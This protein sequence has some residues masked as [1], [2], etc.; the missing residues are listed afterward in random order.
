MVEEKQRRELRQPFK[1]RARL[2]QLLGDQLIGSPRLAVFEL[3]KNA[4]DADAT[5]VRVTLSKLGTSAATIRVRDDGDG[6]SLDLIRNVWLVPGDD[7]REKQRLALTR[8]KK[9]GR[10]PLGEKGVGRFAVHKLGNEIALAT[11]ADGE[12]ECFAKISWTELLE[13]EF[14][15]D[16]NVVVREQESKYFPPPVTGTIIQVKDLREKNWTRRDVRELYRQV[17]S[18]TSPFDEASDSF[19]VVVDIPSRPEWLRGIPDAKTLL[20]MAPWYFEFSFEGG[21]LTVKYRFSGIRDLKVDGR[22]FERT[23]PL[24]IPGEIEPDDLDPASE[25][26]KRRPGKVVADASTVEGIGAVKGRFYVFDRDREILSKLSES[27]LIER[28]LDQNGGV[29]VYRDGIR[30]YNYGEPGDDWLGL[31]LRRVNTPTKNISRNIVVGAIDLKLEESGQLKEKT[32]REGFVENDAYHRLQRIVLGALAIF[33]TERRLDKQR[34]RAATGKMP[35]GPRGMDGPVT[36]LRRLARRNGVGDELEPAIRRIEA[37]YGSLRQSFLTAG[38]SQVGLALVFHEIER[39]VGVLTRAIQAGHELS[40]L[41]EQAGELQ[42]VLET[43]TQLLRK[44]EQKANSLKRLVRMARDISS[45]RFQAHKVRLTCPAM[46]ESAPDATP[47]FDF[48]LALGALTNLI[49]NAI[50]WLKVAKPLD[51]ETQRKLYINVIPDYPDGPAIIIADN[52]TGFSDAPE[53]L[54]QPFFSRRPEGMGLG[55]YYTNLVMQLNG[56]RL[57]FP[58]DIDADQ[59]EDFDGAIVGLVFRRESSANV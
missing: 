16:A 23:E 52:G 37:E 20:V 32:N 30:V 2:L 5:N 55:L 40:A 9:H 25:P 42:R 24:Q 7:Y 17:T 46:E 3:V 47:I 13:N 33:E 6:M 19:N 18:I 49:D 4:Y 26:R 15:E 41:R 10:L 43:S 35:E 48:N 44:G 1:P 56:G 59:P 29:R 31:D 53:Q 57:I 12:A 27:R 28:Y 21:T 50:H 14:L 34:L 8:T 51:S 58:S 11:R 22:E 45:L 54:V 36:E 38:L 39:G